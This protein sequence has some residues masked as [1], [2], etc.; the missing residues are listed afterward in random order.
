[1][2]SE[3][4]TFESARVSPCTATKICVATVVVSPTALNCEDVT[5]DGLTNVGDGCLV[6]SWFSRVGLVAGNHPVRVN[7]C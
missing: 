7:S 6:H 4:V 3:I 1:M 2:V 5:F